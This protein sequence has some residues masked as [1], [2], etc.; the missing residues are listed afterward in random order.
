MET[1]PTTP[2]PFPSQ[3][4]TPKCVNKGLPVYFSYAPNSNEKPEWEHIADCVESLRKM[5]DAKNIEYCIDDTTESASDI[6]DFEKNIGKWNAKVYVLVFSDRYFRSFHCMYEFVQIK[7]AIKKDPNKRLF[8]IKSG[9]FN[10]SDI[11]YILDLEH[12]WGDQKQ[13]YEEVGYHHTRTLKGIEHAAHANVFY[14][15]DIRSLYSFF[16]TL[17][18]SNATTQDWSGLVKEISNSFTQP[19]KYAQKVAQAKKEKNT[20]RKF[21][22]LGCALWGMI[23]MVFV[24]LL[25]I[26]ALCVWQRNPR[27]TTGMD[28]L[29]ITSVSTLPFCFTDVEL[30]LYNPYDHD[31]IVYS[32]LGC[33]MEVDGKKYYIQKVDSLPFYPDY[34][35]LAAHD[36]I[37]CN[38]YFPP[39][40][41]S[42]DSI[43]FVMSPEVGVFGIK[44]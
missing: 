34:K 28:G 33:F 21:M 43:D 13:E 16:S 30:T 22:G 26:T 36:S 44:L 7:N 27:C 32:S 14:M 1:S 12:F 2:P 3:P 31:T 20:K 42:T 5:F 35:I 37:Q 23:F 41:I 11:N 38:F 18:Y 10:L 29:A 19:S 4:L 8:C 6:S 17:N 40:P 25:F 24:V 9:N 15:S 39:I